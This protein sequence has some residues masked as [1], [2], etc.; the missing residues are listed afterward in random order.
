MGI[1]A[2]NGTGSRSEKRTVVQKERMQSL[3]TVCDDGRTS[4]QAPETAVQQTH[5]CVHQRKPLA[6]GACSVIFQDS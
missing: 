6:Q 3:R 5:Q 4:G 2:S 1:S